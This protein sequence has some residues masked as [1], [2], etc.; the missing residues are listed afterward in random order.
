M[1]ASVVPKYFQVHRSCWLHLS[2]WGSPQQLSPSP[3]A[4]TWFAPAKRCCFMN[5]TQH[6]RQPRCCSS[7][8]TFNSLL[9][10]F[11][12]QSPSPLLSLTLCSPS[13]WWEAA[14]ASFPGPEEGGWWQ[15][16]LVH[17]PAS[18]QGPFPFPPVVQRGNLASLS[19]FTEL[20]TATFRCEVSQQGK[21]LIISS[22][23]AIGRCVATPGR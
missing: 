17:P 6:P 1:K 4:S 7:A 13:R 11:S 23:H 5:S 10:Y 19:P 9:S 12:L 16:I 21:F 8:H 2:I 14:K 3:V 18:F 15:D 22:Y 20:I